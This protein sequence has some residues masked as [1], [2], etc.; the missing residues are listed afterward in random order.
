MI[1]VIIS[2]TVT[3]IGWFGP[4]GIASVLYLLIVIG[5]LGTKGFEYMISVVALTVLLSVF[6]HGI[7]AIPLSNLYGRFAATKGTDSRR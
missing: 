7:S 2:C 5:K 3:F 6:L 1:C 4:R